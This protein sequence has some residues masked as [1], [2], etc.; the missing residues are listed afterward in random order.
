MAHTLEHE[1]VLDKTKELC[2]LIV[3]QPGFTSWKQRV[4]AFSGDLGAQMQYQNVM[5]KGDALNQK[6]QMGAPLSDDE[7]SDFEKHREALLNNPV[8][9]D[10][11]DAQEEMHRLQR[12]VNDY[13]SKA[14]QLGRVP[15]AED[16]QEGSCG[17]GC[18]CA[19]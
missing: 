15:S 13:V 6:Q 2:G 1:I 11:L 10:F 5:M 18:G 12:S 14:F 7:I 9:K 4:D 16:L 19:H 3:T 17:S 8:A